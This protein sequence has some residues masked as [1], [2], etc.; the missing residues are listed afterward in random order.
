MRPLG[1]NYVATRAIFDPSTGA[2]AYSVGAEVP[3]SAVEGDNAWLVLGDDVMPVEGARLEMPKRSAS[4]AAWVNF[5][6]GEG[7]TRDEAEAASRADLIEQYGGER[8]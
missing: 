4:H 6:V 1:Y 7:A 5:A 8:A 2:R 3:D